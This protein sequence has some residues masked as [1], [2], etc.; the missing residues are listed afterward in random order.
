MARMKDVLVDLNL[1][2]LPL[3]RNTDPDTSKA[4][5]MKV[6][7]RKGS[8]QMLLLQAFGER[9][10][11]LTD[12]EAG[13]H[14]L[15]AFKPKCGYWKRCSELRH[16]G[17]IADTGVRRNSSAGSPMMVCAITPEGLQLLEASK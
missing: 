8:Q 12:E 9:R 13:V 17:L 2:D 14:T 15:L 6:Q 1:D 5:A 11:G 16:A 7:P 4:G 10:L 3:F